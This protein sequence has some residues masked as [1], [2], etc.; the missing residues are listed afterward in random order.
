MKGNKKIAFTIII[1]LLISIAGFF[2]YKKSVRKL[3][4]T[5]YAHKNDSI[6]LI[7][8][9]K[10]HPIKLDNHSKDGYEILIYKELFYNSYRNNDDI[11]VVSDS[12]G[13]IIIDTTLVLSK[14]N[15]HG[16]V[17]FENPVETNYKRKVC[18]L[19]DSAMIIY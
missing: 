3:I 8:N 4:V 10:R 1:I 11:H 2:L 5:G 13:K 9:S 15:T 19:N 14:K 12:S 7:I 18:L 17:F 6:N 16:R